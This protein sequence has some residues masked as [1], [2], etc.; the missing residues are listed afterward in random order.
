MT[1]TILIF[2][3]LDLILI[4]SIGLFIFNQKTK[5]IIENLFSNPIGKFLPLISLT[6]Y[7]IFMN[8][9]E[10]FSDPLPKSEENLTQWQTHIQMLIQY[11]NDEKASIYMFLI[12]LTFVVSILELLVKDTIKNLKEK[13]DQNKRENENLKTKLAFNEERYS[14]ETLML[15]NA[16]HNLIENFIQESF[17]EFCLGS[18]ERINLYFEPLNIDPSDEDGKFLVRSCRY[19]TNQTYRYSTGRNFYPKSEGL[20]GMVW[21]RGD[22]EG[23]TNIIENLPDPSNNLDKYLSEVALKTNL[24]KTTARQLTF[25]A[26][27]LY[28][29]RLSI[30]N[31]PLAILLIESENTALTKEQQS[32]IEIF[33]S[34]RSYSMLKGVINHARLNGIASY[35]MEVQREGF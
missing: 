17:T 12:L 10:F 6:L 27:S 33:L 5:E 1:I 28:A 24:K 30:D 20:V 16:N 21:L 34:S 2:G 29:Y 22:G 7:S 9:L 23:E 32:K 4:S 31:A 18:K 3:F 19:S 14:E 25:K 26:R 15:S 13:L 11:L 35:I 8:I